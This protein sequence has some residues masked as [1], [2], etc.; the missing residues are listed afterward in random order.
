[1]DL[2]ESTYKQFMQTEEYGVKYREKYHKIATYY[3]FF[4][5]CSILLNNGCINER[6]L[7]TELFT[8]ASLHLN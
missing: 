4:C 3:F 6:S 1:M 8:Q 5:L 7:P 2:A